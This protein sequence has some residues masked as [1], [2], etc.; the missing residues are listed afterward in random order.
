MIQQADNKSRRNSC[1]TKVRHERKTDA[2]RAM[3]LTCN[4]DRGQVYRCR[5]CGGWHWGHLSRRQ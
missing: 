3:R 5:Y 4:R 1:E 2:M